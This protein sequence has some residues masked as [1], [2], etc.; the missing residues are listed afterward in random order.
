VPGY[1][2]N[3][4]LSKQQTNSTFHFHLPSPALLP[5][6]YMYQKPRVAGY[7]WTIYMALANAPMGSHAGNTFGFWF[8]IFNND[9]SKYSFLTAI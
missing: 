8:K 3:Y 6:R 5:E 4:K 1:I 9:L 2:I 7:T